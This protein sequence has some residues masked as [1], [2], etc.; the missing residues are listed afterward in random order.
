LIGA[1]ALMSLVNFR[2]S[3]VRFDAI[4]FALLEEML[5]ACQ[6]SFV[7]SSCSCTYNPPYQ[8]GGTCFVHAMAIE[9]VMSMATPKAAAKIR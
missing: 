4:A 5:K 1:P 6:I 7:N 8:S 3:A 9:K 2:L